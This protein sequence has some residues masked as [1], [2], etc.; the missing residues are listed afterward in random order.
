MGRYW[1]GYL[2]IYKVVVKFIFIF[3]LSEINT[4]TF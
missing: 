3:L 2:K 4:E 1:G